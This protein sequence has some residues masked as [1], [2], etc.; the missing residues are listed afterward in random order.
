MILVVRRDAPYKNLKELLEYE[1]KNPGKIRCGT[2]GVKSIGGFQSGAF[3]DA[4]RVRAD[5][6][7]F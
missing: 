4:Y 6:C 3:P 1:K 2:A 5:I 7:S